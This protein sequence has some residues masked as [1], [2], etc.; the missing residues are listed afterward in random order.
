MPL[1]GNWPFAEKDVGIAPLPSGLYG[2]MDVSDATYAYYIVADTPQREACWAW[3]K[4]LSVH[5]QTTR[6][7]PAHIE[8][9]ESDAF[10]DAVGADVVDVYRATMNNSTPAGSW[11]PDWMAPAQWWLID[12]YQ[13]AV[14]D[15][16]VE[17]A[18][19]NAEAKFTRYRQCII[20]HNAFE[21]QAQQDVCRIAVE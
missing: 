3:I 13:D 8:T 9:A 16:D 1:V 17:G 4:F 18:L 10:S 15:G 19:A 11:L 7:L 14:R 5:P 20:D 2:S 12:A 21:D 6:F